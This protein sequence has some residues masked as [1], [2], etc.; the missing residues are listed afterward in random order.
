MMRLNKTRRKTRH[1]LAA[2]EMAMLLPVFLLLLMGIMDAAR[3]FWTQGVVRDAAFEGARM[4]VLNEPTLDQIK[5]VIQ[6]ELTAGGVS[7]ESSVEVGAREPSQPV[8]V[9]VSVPFEFLVIDNLIPSLRDRCSQ[10]AATAV[11][12]HER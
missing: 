8:D 7:Q 2:V 10:V 6:R 3:L 9:T 11:M 12:T 4:A 5:T 1:G